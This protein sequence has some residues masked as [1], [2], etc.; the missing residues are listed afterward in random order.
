MTHSD[1]VT[2]AERWLR[3]TMH[4]RVVLC[5]LTAYTYSRE[6]PDAIGWVNG[7]SILVE[8]KTSRGDF[9]ADRKKPSRRIPGH[10]AMGNRRVYLTPPGLLTGLVL[11]KGWSWYEAHEKQVRHRAGPLLMH[12]G[13]I[14]LESCLHSEIAILVSALTRKGR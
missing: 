1:L 11:P 10:S 14:P 12:G 6:T 3:N 7:Q 5:E 9:K 2:R 4:C 8:A 13:N